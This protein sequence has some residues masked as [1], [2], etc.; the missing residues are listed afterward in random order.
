MRVFLLIVGLCVV[1]LGGIGWYIYSQTTYTPEWHRSAE[2]NA[3]SG[4]HTEG[5]VLIRRL[6]RELESDGSTSLRASDVEDLI[7]FVLRDG[8]GL[9][10]GEV[11]K[12]ARTRIDDSGASLELVIDVDAV[13]RSAAGEKAEGMLGGL[14][15]LVPDELFLKVELP[16]DADG[17]LLPA[18]AIFHLGKLQFSIE[19]VTA[20]IE[21][22][23]GQDDELR[24]GVDWLERHRFSVDEGALVVTDV[25][26]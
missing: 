19:D 10:A 13:S 22:E 25:S 9:R 2:S 5:E 15:E 8:A 21:E 24:Q 11:I 3:W 20:R 14:G 1:L 4:S 16:P 23:A 17:E 12:G 7:A 18:G 26:G 6:R